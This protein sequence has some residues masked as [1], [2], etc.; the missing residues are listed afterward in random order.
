MLRRERQDD[1]RKYEKKGE[2]EENVRKDSAREREK[3]DEMWERIEREREENEECVRED[4][5]EMRKWRRR[6][7]ER[8]TTKQREEGNV[9]KDS[10]KEKQQIERIEKRKKNEIRN[11]VDNCRQCKYK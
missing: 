3:N 8:V 1:W 10:L 5:E 6:K 7:C 9:K 4:L 2:N 11:Y